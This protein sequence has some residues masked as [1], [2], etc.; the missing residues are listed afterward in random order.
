[1]DG[2]MIA[3]IAIKPHAEFFDYTAKYTDGGT[4]EI[5]IQL[6][7]ELDKKVEEMAIGCW[8]VLKCQVYVR[9]DMIIQDGVPY[10]LELNTLPG[11]TN[12]SLFPKGAKGAG[13]SYTELLNKITEASLKVER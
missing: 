1:M 12:N 11:M 4:D 10:V 13:I 7:G 8:N 2:K 3:V 6:E 9:V 5:V